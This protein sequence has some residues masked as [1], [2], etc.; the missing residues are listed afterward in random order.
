[1][2]YK[3]DAESTYQSFSPR[4]PKSN[5]SKLNRERAAKLTAQGL[6]MPAG[7]AMIDVAK[8]TGTWT[9]LV[10]VEKAIIPSD[11]KKQFDKSQKAFKN[12][13]SFPPSSK[14]IILTWIM[15]AKKPDTRLQRI[16]KTVE[17]AKQN[18][19]ANHY[20]KK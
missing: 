9:A 16:M 10:E 3:R 1:V 13:Q 15:S 20:T 18:V 4:K 14:M 6:M 17:L 19:R 5:W 12:F 2:K 11:L 8:K 7:Q